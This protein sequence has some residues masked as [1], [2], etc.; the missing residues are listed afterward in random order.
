VKIPMSRPSVGALE[1][2]AVRRVFESGWLGEGPLTAEFERRVAALT[3]APHA[4]AVNTGTSALHLALYVLGVGPGDEVIVP[5]L[6]FVADP[7]VVRLCG[8]TPVFA[9]IEPGSLNLDPRALPALLTRRT[10]AVL[11]TDYAGLPADVRAMRRALRG[12]GKRV[13]IVR[14]A[15]HSFGSLLDGRMVGV[16]AGEDLT[17]LSFDPIKNVTCG[18]G[19]VILTRSAPLARRLRALKRLGQQEGSWS[20]FA[21]GRER[22]NRVAATGFRYHLS[23]INA[24]IGLTQLDRLEALLDVRRRRAKRYDDRLTGVAG[25][26]RL[27]RDYDRIVPFMYVIRVPAEVR[28]G[29]VA[30]LG[31]NGVHSG[32]RYSPCH[33]QPAFRRRGQSL[34]VTEQVTR[35]MLSLP[36]YADLPEDAVDRVAGLVASYL[37]R[38]RRRE[39]TS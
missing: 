24:A 4:V 27:G 9:E 23:D 18:E 14:D 26:T 39:A 31:E 16:W 37:G 25:I 1:L 34:P 7:M 17:C 12:S 32:L 19:G 36:L 15:S 28:D 8:A 2:E 3:G 6:T 29:L 38:A 35:E 22:N 30:F 11:P 20:R 13:R 5:S 10:R 33:L 21:R